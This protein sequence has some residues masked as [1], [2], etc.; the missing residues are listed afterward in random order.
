MFIMRNL[1]LVKTTLLGIFC[2]AGIANASLPINLSNY[3]SNGS[4]KANLIA[5]NPSENLP[6]F[7][8]KPSSEE[9]PP[10]EDKPSSEK[11]PPVEDKPS[12][13][14]QP[15]VED[16]PSSEEQPPVEDKPSSGEQPP[17]EDK[18]SSGEQPPVE[19]KPSSGEQPP[20]EDKPSSTLPEN[21]NPSPNPLLFPTQVDEVKASNV[22]AITLQQAIDL[23]RKNNKDLELA[24]LNLD[25]SQQQLRE[26]LATE[27][28]TATASMDFERTDAANIEL[29]RPNDNS[30]TT[31]FTTGVELNYNLYTG[32]RRAAQIK[33]AEKQVN[34]DQLDVERISEEIRLNVSNDYYALQA[35]DA[36]VNI[37]EAAVNDAKQS[38]RDAQLLEQAGLGTRFDVITAQ[39]DVANRELELV[40][41]IAAQKVARRQ[42]VERIGLAQNVELMA[43]DKIEV[44][45]MWSLPLEETILLAYK[46]R[47]ELE[48]F[49]IQKE[50]EQQRQ[51]LEIAANKP[52]VSLFTNYDVLAVA[53]DD[54]GPADGFGIGAR[55]RWNFYDGGVAK[56]RQEQS[57][58]D[59]NISETRFAQERDRIRF[60]VETAYYRLQ[61]NNDNIETAT[62]SVVLAEESLRL[63]RL[64]FQAGVGTQ[65]DVIT[66]QTELT[67]TRGDLLRTVTVYNQQ[68]A[69]L[70]RAV[71]NLPDNN[72]FDVP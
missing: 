18:P 1:F 14:E 25:K 5:Q 65:S 56:A 36:L 20:V 6:V 38:L 44:V 61:A 31:S 70:E 24:S 2:Y 23:A 60:E 42:L 33:A 16:K 62:Q 63:A 9:Q 72:L 3:R 12:S 37:E 7:E 58:V 69:A 51:K 47:V 57:K 46:N 49:L 39:V 40:Q 64:R 28:P 45:P 15:P 34:F 71:S 13:E 59:E 50:I 32:G 52:Q 53:N 21:I 10:V 30:V 66:A 22:Q 17:V 29:L 26:A 4:L 8:E 27:L 35:A 54:V 43:A 19:D 48:Q 11:Q 41:A 67:R 55:V 68:L